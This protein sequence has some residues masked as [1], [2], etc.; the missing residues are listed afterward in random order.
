MALPTQPGRY[1]ATPINWTVEETGENKLPTFVC[2]FELFQ[3]FGREGWEEISDL[4]II[5]YFFLMKKDGAINERQIKSLRDALSWDGRSIAGLADGQWTGVEVQ[6]ALGCEEYKGQNKIKV[7]FINPRDYEPGH[8]SKNPETVKA[9]GSRI[10]MQLRALAG[11]APA[12][13]PAPAKPAVNNPPMADTLAQE[14]RK[15][16]WAA[17]QGKNPGMTSEALIEPWR[18]QIKAVFPDK[19]STGFTA[20]DWRAVQHAIEHPPAMAMAGGGA[21]PPFGDE[22]AFDPGEIPF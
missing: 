18:A 16:A 6:L 19:A 11:S 14:A 20:E 5:G 3:Y 15:R 4:Q 8:L 2:S 10:D 1:L 21:E 7:Q 17:F 9:I 22:Q 13:K 12:A